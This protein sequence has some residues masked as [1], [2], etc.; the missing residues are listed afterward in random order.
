MLGLVPLLLMLS[1]LVMLPLLRTAAVRRARSCLVWPRPVP[2]LV[3]CT[4][5]D[6]PQHPH[7]HTPHTPPVRQA[8]DPVEINPSVGHGYRVMSVDEWAAR[9]KR[10]DAFPDCLQCGGKSTK[11]HHFTQVCE[12][13]GGGEGAQTHPGE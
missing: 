13:G 5:A 3:A 11:E 6:A 10:N 1:L 12:R 4:R 8:G 9:W 7:P 2:A